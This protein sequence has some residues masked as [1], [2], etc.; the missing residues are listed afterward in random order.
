MFVEWLQAARRRPAGP[1]AALRHLG[2]LGLFFLAI[3][4]SSPLPT[5]GGPDILIVILVVT[6]R[7]P[8]WECVAAATAGSVIGAWLTFRL[9]RRAGRAYL[10]GKFGRHKAPRLLTL[11]EK[12][13]TGA[14]VAS[15]A[16]PFPF[17]TSVFFAAAGASNDYGTRKYLAVVTLSRAV[18]YSAVALVAELYG[19]GVIRILRHPAQH[20]GW[21]LLAIAIFVVVIL[22]GIIIHL[23]LTAVSAGHAG[24]RTVSQ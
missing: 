8:W 24:S 4:D 14:L 1:A 20:W 22:T 5:F 19:R 6:R 12:W 21:S 16:I 9:A 13:G 10:D 3:L 18:R 17:P 15:T 7:D 2:A 23:R 11:F